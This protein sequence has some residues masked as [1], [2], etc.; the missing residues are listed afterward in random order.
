MGNFHVNYIQL[1]LRNLEQLKF[2][3]LQSVLVN[4]I[5]YSIIKDQTASVATGFKVNM[6]LTP[7]N[8]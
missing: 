6:S 1:L 3:M 8:W 5:V 2:Y 7:S 4:M